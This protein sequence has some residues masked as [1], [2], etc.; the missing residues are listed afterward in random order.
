[1][2]KYRPSRVSISGRRLSPRRPPTAEE[3]ESFHR[4]FFLPLVWRVTWKHGI[5]KEDAK[6]IVQEAFLL[7]LGKL[8]TG[9]NP[10]AWLTRVVDNLSVNHMRK[11]YRRTRL[12]MRWG[13]MSPLPA[14][15]GANPDSQE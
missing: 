15:P 6:D 8:D 14:M 1:V 11:L 12:T 4:D 13:Q 7:A 10:R 3:L 5:T 2:V 9:G